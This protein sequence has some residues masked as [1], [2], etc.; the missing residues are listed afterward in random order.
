[1]KIHHKPYI[2][3]IRL[4]SAARLLI[5]SVRIHMLFYLFYLSWIYED[6]WW[7]SISPHSMFFNSLLSNPIVAYNF[8]S[9]EEW[10]GGRG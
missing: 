2:L 5:D 8:P 1:V 9:Q 7:R 6:P 10:K 4:P 3:V